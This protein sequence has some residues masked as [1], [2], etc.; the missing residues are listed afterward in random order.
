[1]EFEIALLHV[2]YARYY[3]IHAWPLI[4]ADAHARVLDMGVWCNVHAPLAQ[5]NLDRYTDVVSHA[6]LTDI[7]FECYPSTGNNRF[8]ASYVSEFRL[9]IVIAFQCFSILIRDGHGHKTL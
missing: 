1:M 2:F 9:V 8:S 4:R 3:R 7:R 6:A 5:G